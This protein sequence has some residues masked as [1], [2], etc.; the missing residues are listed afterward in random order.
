MKVSLQLNHFTA[1]SADRRMRFLKNRNEPREGRGQVWLQS[2]DRRTWGQLEP[3]WECWHCHELPALSAWAAPGLFLGC[4]WAAPGLLLPVCGR[5][6][7][8]MSQQGCCCR[9]GW[10]SLASSKRCLCSQGWPGHAPS[11]SGP[12]WSLS[13][14][15]C[16][17]FTSSFLFRSF[18]ELLQ[19]LNI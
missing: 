10:A 3:S 17:L 7:C 18:R 16:S 12:A 1:A 6:S 14:W 15:L 5:G 2:S 11:A 8:W 4:S 13:Y 19:T 9:P